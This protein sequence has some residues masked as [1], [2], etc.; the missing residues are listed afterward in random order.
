[1][2]LDS[3]SNPQS[4]KIYASDRGSA[5]DD[6]RKFFGNRRLTSLVVDQLQS[7][8]TVL[9]LSEADF[10]A[11]IRADCSEAIFSATA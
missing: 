6:F 2:N 7:P 8:I 1:M 11:T 9:A 10:M 4:I 5:A 3:Y